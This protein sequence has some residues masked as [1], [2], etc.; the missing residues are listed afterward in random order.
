MITTV[1]FRW[2]TSWIHSYL[3]TGSIAAILSVRIW[4]SLFVTSFKAGAELLANTTCNVNIHTHKRFEKTFY[5]MWHFCHHVFSSSPLFLER[6]ALWRRESPL[7]WCPLHYCPRKTRH[8]YEEGPATDNQGK[9]HWSMN[10]MDRATQKQHQSKRSV[11]TFVM[12]P[13]GDAQMNYVLTSRQL[14]V[15]NL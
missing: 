3:I 14:N 1:K 12:F 13:D 9:M 8:T 11:V 10:R 5:K 15:S 6:E 2:V 7:K 4:S